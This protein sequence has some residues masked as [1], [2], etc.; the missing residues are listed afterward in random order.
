MNR[1]R[2]L[3][4]VLV[5]AALLPAPA[6]ASPSGVL[7]EA[8]SFADPGGWATDTQFIDIMG[9][10]YLLAH[11][12]GEP[13]RDATTTVSFPAAGR[14]R[15]YV[16]TKDW[17]ARWKAPGAPGRFQLIVDGRPLAAVFGAEGAEWHWQDGG[18]VEV[19]KTEVPVALRDLTGF[20]G[21]C[22]AVWFAKEGSAKPPEDPKALA[23]WRRE[24][25]GHPEKPEE[26]GPFDLVVVGGGIPGTCAAISAARLGCT[27]ALVQDRPVLGG[28]GS[29]EVR[30]WPQGKTR[31][32]L[33]PRLGEIVE[34]ISGHPKESPGKAEE[35]AD[36]TK[37]AVV[38]AEPKIALFL[39][40]YARRVEVQGGRIAAVV[41]LEVRT[42]RERRFAGRL[43]ADCTGHGTIG[44]LAGADLTVMK[45]GHMGMSNMWRWAEAG[46]PSAFPATPWA[47]DLEMGDFPYPGRGKGE[48][49]WETGFDKD[50][51]ADLE[52]MRDWNLRAV[53]GAFH[54]MKNK[55][56][57][58]KHANAR[59]EWVAYIGGTRESRQLL[60]DVVLSKDDIA[61]KAAYP[62]GCVPTT[63]DID[64]H[65]PEQKYQKKYPD[66]PFISRAQFDR[67]VDKAQG[68]PVPYRCFYSRNVP[69]LFVAGRDISVTHE[70][71]GTVRVMKTGGM[72]GEV[73]G[74]AASICLKRGCLPRDVYGKHLEELKDLMRMPGKARRESVQGEP[75]V[76]AGADAAPA[77]A[78]AHADGGIAPGS[79]PG[80]VVDDTQAKLTG[81]WSEGSSLKGFIGDR[82]LYDTKKGDS[83]ARFEFTIGKAGRYE[84]R[85]AYRPH[86][87][88]ATNVPVTVA[89]ADGEKAV[90]VN[91][92]NAP[93]LPGGFVSLGVFRFEAG[94]AGAVVVSNQGADGHVCIDAVQVVP[95]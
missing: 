55:E 9:S 21:R 49:F 4:P 25:L 59:L 87:N 86:E 62:D 45:E 67:K 7:V 64:L 90:T 34:E 77:G 48:W 65:Y 92:R 6:P 93:S 44:A 76:P 19:A 16:R 38:R 29:S 20:D 14:Y 69:N 3:V 95:E 80:I 46:A 2:A 36:A 1:L 27:V 73:V 74:K 58:A 37:E 71:L 63:W 75:S 8:E 70:A 88:R 72:M 33:F 53:F 81:G 89:S 12:L 24:Q 22:D 56:G 41:A 42:G 35:F 91:Q 39:G 23:V 85:L 51:L 26:A 82:Y 43:F 61:S 84:V 54:A 83:T 94:K 30:V 60:G 10:P 79:L 50:P 5:L 52:A 40:H 13:V 47:L 32:G 11:G 31:I 68:Y 18:T 57:K 17:V 15:V 78:A 66:D 28:N